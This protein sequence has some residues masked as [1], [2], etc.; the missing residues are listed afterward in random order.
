MGVSFICPLKMLQNIVF[1]LLFSGAFGEWVD[2]CADGFST[3][4]EC[5]QL[6]TEVAAEGEGDPTYTDNG[7]QGHQYKLEFDTRTFSSQSF[8]CRSN[9]LDD[10][11][12]NYHLV[13]FETRKEYVCV[14]KWLL[15]E[16]GEQGPLYLGMKADASE[17]MKNL[18]E[19]DKPMSSSDGTLAFTAWSPS[20]PN[21]LDCV[22]V[23]VGE[24]LSTSGLWV[25][26]ECSAELPTICETT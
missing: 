12:N 20:A 3:K 25:D 7:M 6:N 26:S 14:M 15:K 11:D 16:Q 8:E 21:G 18:Y 10:S 1:V 4:N 23:A 9:G 17:N 22:T 19:W 13:T 2:V 5:C 24:S